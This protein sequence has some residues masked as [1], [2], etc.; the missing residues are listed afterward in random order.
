MVFLI[1][2]SYTN[3]SA[4]D[5]KAQK[6]QDKY[7]ELQ[8]NLLASQ[9]INKKIVDKLPVLQS[10]LPNQFDLLSIISVIETISTKTKFKI[11]SFSIEESPTVPGVVNQK[12]IDIKGIG[13]FAEFLN[14]IKEYK[15]ISGKLLSLD[16]V[17]LS[18]AEEVVSSLSI[19]LYAQDPKIDPS[20]LPPNQIDPLD[21]KILQLI[22]DNIVSQKAQELDDTF[23]EKGNPFQ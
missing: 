19:N 15:Y 4:L 20:Q 9:V 23:S 2:A 13:T 18:G 5:T 14:F 10:F 17:N 6:S 7:D 21:E 16:T 22:E 12:K 1:S 11:N 8:R 3:Y